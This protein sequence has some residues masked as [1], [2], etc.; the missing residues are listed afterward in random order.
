MADHG[1]AFTAHMMEKL[2][3]GRKTQT[4]RL[5]WKIVAGPNSRHVWKRDGKHIIN[6]EKVRT[7]TQL[8]QVNDRIWVREALQAF[9]GELPYT[10]QYAV[11][12]TGVPHKGRVSGDVRGRAHWRWNTKY[13]SARFCPRWASRLT[14]T[15]IEKRL[16]RLQDISEED[17]LADG[18]WT[19]QDCPFH[20]AP[21]KSFTELWDNLHVAGAWQENPEVVA[22]TFTV[23]AGN[24]DDG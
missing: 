11:D 12:L 6:G 22:L 2:L 21:I 10:A 18:G 7:R 14:L 20:K 16:E 3:D 15:V 17:A 23:R 13:L 9:G 4:R 8:I 19:Y 1:V 24:I 5:A